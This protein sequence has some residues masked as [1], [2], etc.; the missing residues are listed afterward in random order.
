MSVQVSYK[1]QFVLAILLLIIIL[2]VIEGV[3]KLWWQNIEN[4]AFEDSDVYADLPQSLKRQM[5]VESYQVRFSPSHIEPNQNFETI[6]INS[7]GFRGK[8]ISLEKPEN[9]FR[10]FT[11]G[12]STM[13]G[14]GSTSDVTTIPGFL[15][16]KFDKDNLGIVVEVINAG[17][18]G[19]WSQTESN[20]V[21]TTLLQFSPDLLIIYDGWNDASVLENVPDDEIPE[22]ISQWVSRWN[23]ICDLGRQMNFET[24]ITIQPM[25]G[26]GNKTLSKDEY[27]YSLKLQQTK[28]LQRLDLFA[29]GLNDL[30]NSCTAT[31]DL[32]GSFDGLDTPIYWDYGHM[33]NAGN[34][35]ISQKMY[36]LSLPVVLSKNVTENKILQEPPVSSIGNKKDNSFKDAYVVLKRSVL[37]NYKTPLMIRQFFVQSQEQLVTHSIQIEKKE[38][39]NLDLTS[40]LSHADLSKA[41]YPNVDFSKRDLSGTNF[42]GT[43]LRKS[44]FN[45]ANLSSANMTLANLSVANMEG[46][47]LQNVD[48]RQSDLTGAILKKSDMRGVN[49]LGA[50]LYNTN[51]KDANLQGVDLSTADLLSV[52]FGGSDLSY[53]KLSGMDLRRMVL[54]NSNLTSANLQGTFLDYLTIKGATLRGA[55]L[56]GAT[57]HFADFSHMNLAETDFSDAS[58]TGTDFSNSDLTRANFEGALLDNVDFSNSNLKNAK[59]KPFIGCKNHPLCN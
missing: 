29:L 53:A 42:F 24:I 7:F 41:Y 27:E 51:L 3:A 43:Y 59:G 52:D 4:C 56:N 46:A 25:V 57:I 34:D 44:N 18:S 37:Q 14:T 2:A 17:V 22:K 5:C 1:K 12:G 6:N 35:I 19:A 30:K 50:K 39:K 48:F 15:Q 8:V 33:A 10:I 28:I 9:T 55:N 47:N 36:E 20:Y 31:V 26:T 16:Q 23:E 58:L 13:L 45:E 54:I 38:S 32:R 21:K 40:N 11:V 49:L